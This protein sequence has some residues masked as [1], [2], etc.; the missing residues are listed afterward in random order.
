MTVKSNLKINNITNWQQL[1]ERVNAKR[2]STDITTKAHDYEL[3]TSS[4]RRTTAQRSH[5]DDII[6]TKKPV[7]LSHT[8]TG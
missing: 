5:L 7:W 8:N 6:D 4:S 1:S 2:K 3:N